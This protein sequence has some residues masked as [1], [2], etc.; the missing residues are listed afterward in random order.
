M[1]EKDEKAISKL[2][3]ELYRLASAKATLNDAGFVFHFQC[4]SG[5]YRIVHDF[6]LEVMDAVHAE[7]FG[8]FDGIHPYVTVAKEKFGVLVL[9]TSSPNEMIRPA[10]MAACRR[11][12]ERSKTTCEICGLW[13]ELLTADGCYRVRCKTCEANWRDRIY[14]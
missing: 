5:W 13:G 3:P 7:G 10:L 4:H 8:E 1:N 14:T 11:A 6:T 2:Y 12:A 9:A